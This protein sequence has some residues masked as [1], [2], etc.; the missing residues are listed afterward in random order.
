MSSVINIYIP[1]ALIVGMSWASFWLPLDAVPARVAL[2]VTSLLTLCTQVQQYKANLPPVSYVTA[3]DIWLF[4]CAYSWFSS[5][6]WN[7]LFATVR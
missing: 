1:S 2:S 3:M 6:W 5:H 4:L 7:L